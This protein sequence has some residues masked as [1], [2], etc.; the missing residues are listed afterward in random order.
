MIQ[1]MN[2][3]LSCFQA[4]TPEVLWA[5]KPKSG[6]LSF[7]LNI[8]AS[9]KLLENIKNLFFPFYQSQSVSQLYNFFFYFKLYINISLGKF[10]WNYYY[11]GDILQFKNPLVHVKH[12]NFSQATCPLVQQGAVSKCASQMPEQETWWVYKSC[13]TALYILSC[14]TIKK[15]ILCIIIVIL[16]YVQQLPYIYIHLFTKASPLSSLLS[17]NEGQELADYLK[18]ALSMYGHSS[19][20]C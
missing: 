2:R 7:T 6:Y 14:I 5:I 17:F 10:L 11:W 4:V 19:P 16:S 3:C 15:Q 1:H 9:Y 20:V 12:Q 8:K 13:N 18:Q